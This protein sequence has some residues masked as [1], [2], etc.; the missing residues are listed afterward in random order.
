[1]AKEGMMSIMPLESVVGDILPDPQSRK[2]AR[3]PIDIGLYPT[4]DHITVQRRRFDLTYADGDVLAFNKRFATALND[5]RVK[6]GNQGPQLKPLSAFDLKSCLAKLRKIGSE[7]YACLPSG[8][9][10]YIGRLETDEAERGISL[11]LTFPVKQAFL[12]EMMYTQLPSIDSEESIEEDIHDAMINFWGFRFPMGHLYWDLEIKDWIRLQKGIFASSHEQLGAS[13]RELEQL[14]QELKLVC[15]R[16]GFAGIVKRLEETISPETMCGNEIMELFHREDFVYGIVHFACHCIDPQ[17]PGVS[18]VYLWLK[19][20]DKEVHMTL[21]DFNVRAGHHRGFLYRPLVFLNACGSA[22]KEHLSQSLDF[23]S[24]F[25]NFGAGGVIATAC[26]MPDNFAGAFATEFY[27]RL[28]NKPSTAKQVYIGEA[29]LETKR[30][31]L[32][33]YHNPLGLAYGLYSL[34]NQRLRLT[35]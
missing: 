13:Q 24:G 6:V 14:E 15:A 11:D 27:R 3:L 31:F 29:L 28:L 23:P 34:S 4:G 7:A 30:Y 25:L 9:G 20:H 2:E 17:T 18:E 33:K 32:T 16:L 1:M 22:T 8:V 26:D 5:L 19:A 12:W 35:D 21:G 10:E